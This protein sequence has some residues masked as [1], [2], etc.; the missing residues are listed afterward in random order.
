MAIGLLPLAPFLDF[1]L[2]KVLKHTPGKASGTGFHKEGALL[3]LLAQSSN[4]FPTLFL[5]YILSGWGP[6]MWAGAFAFC[7]FAS[8]VQSLEI[9][10]RSLKCQRFSLTQ[11][12]LLNSKE[13]FP[14]LKD[15]EI[16]GKL[17]SINESVSGSK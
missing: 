6:G 8:P 1:L 15:L 17:K 12:K 2:S 5:G 11:V 16:L 7:A 10:G 13:I 14:P 3:L 4:F 9:L